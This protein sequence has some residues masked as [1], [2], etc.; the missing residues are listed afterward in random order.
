VLS[1][2]LLSTDKPVA[3]RGHQ[4][5][6]NSVAAIFCLTGVYHVCTLRRKRKVDGSVFEGP[7]R[8]H[9]GASGEAPRKGPFSNRHDLPKRVLQY[10]CSAFACSETSTQQ[11]LCFFFCA[12]PELQGQGCR[13][14]ILQ[15][16]FFFPPPSSPHPY[17]AFYIYILFF[18]FFCSFRCPELQGLLAACSP[19]IYKGPLPWDKIE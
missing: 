9:W 16:I 14:H 10:C 12:C 2:V 4:Y 5:Y 7:L 8:M 13:E 18:H 17:Q 11:N 19:H 15:R 3:Q 6:Q 1:C